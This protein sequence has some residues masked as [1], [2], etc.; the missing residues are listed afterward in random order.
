VLRRLFNA[1]LCI[2]ATPG[3]ASAGAPRVVTG[4][5]IEP[6]EALAEKDIDYLS[7]TAPLKVRGRAKPLSPMRCTTD[8]TAGA[9]SLRIHTKVDVNDGTDSSWPIDLNGIDLRLDPPV[10]WSDYDAIAFDMKMSVTG[11]KRALNHLH[12]KVYRDKT[13]WRADVM[14]K[15]SGK[16]QRVQIPF[17]NF[18][19]NLAGF[20]MPDGKGIN[21]IILGVYENCDDHGA[22]YDIHVDNL[23]LLKTRPLPWTKRCERG[24]ALA[25][26]YI[27]AAEEMTILPA[28][29]TE[30]PAIAG[31]ISG[32]GC[33]ITAEHKLRVVFHELFSNKDYPLE[34]ACPGAV[35]PRAKLLMPVTLKIGALPPGYYV[36]TLDVTKGGKSV[37]NGRVG[38][39]DFY[40]Q[41]NG[42]TIEHSLMSHL[43]A[44]SYFAQDRKYG[45]FYKR[46]RA[47]LPHTWSPLDE[48]T[49]PRFLLHHARDASFWIEE[50]HSSVITLTYAAEAFA[51]AG[52]PERQRFAEKMLRDLMAFMTGPIMVNEEGAIIESGNALGAYEAERFPY[53]ACAMKPTRIHTCSMNQTGYWLVCVARAAL[54][55]AGVGNDTAYAKSLLAPMDRAVGFA[56][57]A[58]KQDI[59][60]KSVLWNYFA[61][62]SL[63]EPRW[64]TIPNGPGGQPMQSCCGTRSLTGA[65]FYAYVRQLLAG[66]VDPKALKALKDTAH[67]YGR[68]IEQNQGWADPASQDRFFEANMYLGEGFFGYT[69]YNRLV[70]DKD[71]AARA[72]DWTKLAYLYITD[73]SQTKDGKKIVLEWNNWGGSWFT[74]SFSEY[75]QLLGPDTRTQW[76]VDRIEMQWRSRGFRDIRHRPWRQRRAAQFTDVPPA[77]SFYVFDDKDTSKTPGYRSP[78]RGAIYFS[79]LAPMAIYEFQDT[80]YKSRLLTPKPLRK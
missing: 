30:I 31:L 12:L 54:Y 2:A 50:L 5:R 55:F 62:T 46:V 37:L 45:Y 21:L 65:A 23:R 58:F 40:L 3:L 56:S 27:G 1:V 71:E 15:P 28:G 22:E 25:E 14:V 33:T 18:A 79:W 10:D 72:R 26:L 20:R 9:A 69:L 61:R 80:G 63:K 53:A 66:Q 16:W 60:G 70:G 47:S 75:M 73:R 64:R 34:M 11:S 7:E 78:D 32:R 38:V 52:E 29:T 49:Y 59:D 44:E 17:D 35:I 39:D 4:P 13:S 41:K 36:T 42:E 74:W 43:T 8:K 24:T 77:K 68:I 6:V 48:K 67:W 19:S 76:W 51:R 57:E